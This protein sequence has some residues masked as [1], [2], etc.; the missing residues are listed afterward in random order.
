MTVSVVVP[1]SPV[2]LLNDFA[3]QGATLRGFENGAEA[4]RSVAGAGD[5]NGDGFPDMIIGAPYTA[6]GG[7]S[8]SS[9]MF[10]G[11]EAYV[12]EDF[13]NPVVS[14]ADCPVCPV[15]RKL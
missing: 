7:T 4:G 6:A 15:S 3:N 12:I 14:S 1:A 9:P 8:L 10:T 13:A 2:I 5:F 11:F